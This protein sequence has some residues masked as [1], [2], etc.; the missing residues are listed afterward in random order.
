MMGRRVTTLIALALLRL[1]FLSAGPLE[2]FENHFQQ[3]LDRQN[4]C[5]NVT[6]YIITNIDAPVLGATTWAGKGGSEGTVAP[7]QSVTT[8]PLQ[9]DL[10]VLLFNLPLR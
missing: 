6:R 3:L 2:H 8:P 10:C 1:P 9:L 7:Q 4:P 5:M